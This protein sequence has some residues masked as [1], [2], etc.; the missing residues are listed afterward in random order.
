MESV[1]HLLTNWALMRPLNPARIWKQCSAGFLTLGRLTG[2]DS[3]AKRSIGWM[4]KRSGM[5]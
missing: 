3:P 2:C 5:L 4:S 1:S